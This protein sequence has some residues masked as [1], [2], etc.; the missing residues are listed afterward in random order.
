MLQ[1]RIERDSRSATMS[2]LS[3]LGQSSALYPL[4]PDIEIETPPL[5][6]DLPH[7]MRDSAAISARCRNLFTRIKPII[8]RV[9]T[10]WDH[11][12][13]SIMVAGRNVCVDPS[14]SYKV[15]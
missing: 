5:P 15:E 7:W 3:A 9:L 10:F 14:G 13:R 2:S 11:Q 1:P 8:V 6:R 12:V 4:L